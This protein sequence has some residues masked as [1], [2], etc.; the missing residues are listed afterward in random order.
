MKR[1]PHSCSMEFAKKKEEYEKRIA[2][3]KLRQMKQGKEEAR[4]QEISIMQ[5]I[6]DEYAFK[7]NE[8]TNKSEES[9]PG[10]E[11]C[12]STSST[13]KDTMIE[14]IRKDNNPK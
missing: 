11:E 9:D 5:E 12:S 3:F 2:L 14:I 1:N 10:D 13:S 4:K 8:S 7:N 6:N